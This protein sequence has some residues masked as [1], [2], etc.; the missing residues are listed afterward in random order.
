MQVKVDTRRTINQHIFW[1]WT[2]FRVQVLNGQFN[3]SHFAIF[4]TFDLVFEC[5]CF[6]FCVFRSSLYLSPHEVIQYKEH[7][8]MFKCQWNGRRV[9]TKTWQAFRKSKLKNFCR[10]S[11]W[12]LEI[13]L[14]IG[15]LFRSIAHIYSHFPLSSLIMFFCLPCELICYFSKCMYY[16]F[17][18]RLQ[19]AEE[20]PWPN[21]IIIIACWVR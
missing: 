3:C 16:S 7:W 18:V 2:M 1:H 14:L 9:C 15:V 20:N 21:T 6:W 5:F 4:V 19:W 12:V 13:L 8:Q 10:M 17:I 11:S